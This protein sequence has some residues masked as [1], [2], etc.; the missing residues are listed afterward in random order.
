MLRNGKLVS[1][2]TCILYSIYP[3]TVLFYVLAS[4]LLFTVTFSALINNFVL[5]MVNDY[6][7]I[8]SCE[9]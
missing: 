9:S 8:S 5:Y 4:F 2:C 3:K 6:S 1:S 7:C